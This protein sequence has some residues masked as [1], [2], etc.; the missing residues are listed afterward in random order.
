MLHIDF[1]T[2]DLNRLRVAGNSDF[3]WD[4]VLS[5]QLL[6]NRHSALVYDPWRKQVRERLAQAGLT[7]MTRALMELSPHGPYIPD[8]LTPGHGT[9]DPD[10]GVDAVLSTPKR[11]LGQE[12]IRLYENRPMPEGARRLAQGGSEALRRLGTA[13][14]RYHAVAV[15]PYKT[16]IDHAIGSNRSVRADSALATGAEGLMTSYQPELIWRDG[17][18]EAGYPFDR[19]LE[20]NGRPLT[21][22]PSFF[23]TRWPITLAAPELPPVLVHPLPLAPGWLAEAGRGSGERLHRL[24]GRTRTLVLESLGRPMSTSGIAATLLLSPASASRHAS[25][26]REAGLVSSFRH[27]HSVLH[28]RTALGEALLNGG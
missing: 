14:R 9:S 18:I 5:L 27:G 8:F 6:Q 4:V 2:D 12:L 3:M 20:L 16:A 19:N 23:C 25:V 17:R 7:R 15:A 13:V 1:S 21:L 11:R 24:L 10:T 22:V 28:R 26:L